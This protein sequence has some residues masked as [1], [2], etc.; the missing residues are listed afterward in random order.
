MGI[1]LR[2]MV[3]EQF[4]PRLSA[5]GF[6]P[7]DRFVDAPEKHHPANTCKDAQTV[8]VLGITVS[9][10]MLRSPDY[11]LHLLHLSKTYHLLSTH[12]PESDLHAP[13][14]KSHTQT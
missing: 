11:N 4:S 13:R 2:N 3:A 10:G 8:I 1:E 14:A 7:V 6:A 5:I 9:Q 12:K